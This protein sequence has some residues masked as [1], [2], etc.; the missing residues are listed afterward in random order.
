LKIVWRFGFR[1]SDSGFKVPCLAFRISSLPSGRLPATEL[2]IPGASV[3]E[4]PASGKIYNKS[5]PELFIFAEWNK[6]Y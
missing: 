3:V 5:N 6:L 1:V 2:A 4:V